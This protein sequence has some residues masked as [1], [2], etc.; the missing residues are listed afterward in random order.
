MTFFDSGWYRSVTDFAQHTGWLQGPMKLYTVASIG[1]L[2]VL[3]L[4]LW[5]S[6][7]AR[8]DRRAM[9]AVIWFAAGTLATIICGLLLKQ[10]FTEARPCLQMHVPTVVACP[11]PSDYSFPSDHTLIAVALAAGLW[12]IDRRLGVVAIA[13]ALLEGFSRVYLGQH[14]PHDVFAAIVLGVAVMGGGWWV[15]RRPLTQLVGVLEGTFL[16][17]LFVAGTAANP[18]DSR[19]A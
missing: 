8:A 11:G 19:S 18:V 2:A 1:L 9:A 13:L 10:V 15:V 17:P 12:I 7:R 3:G 4:W 14:Y 6:A 16:R 5:W